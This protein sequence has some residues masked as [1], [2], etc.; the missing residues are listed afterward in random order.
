[1]VQDGRA[2]SLQPHGQPPHS[3]HILHGQPPHSKHILHGRPTHSKHILHG[4]P[5][6]SKHIL[7]GRPPHSKQVAWV[8][9]VPCMGG[10]GP[11]RTW[12]STFT[13]SSSRMPLGSARL[14]SLRLKAYCG[15]TSRRQRSPRRIPAQRAEHEGSGMA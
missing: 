5:P 4:R 7:H 9:T 3:K 11:M 8:D 15:C 10:H 6:H 14:Q 13:G 12:T 2:S 1:M